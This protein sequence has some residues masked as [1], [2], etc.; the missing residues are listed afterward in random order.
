MG[1]RPFKNKE[2]TKLLAMNLGELTSQVKEK[3]NNLLN[4]GYYM[5]PEIYSNTTIYQ[6]C[7]D[8]PIEGIELAH[9]T[10]W[11]TFN[12]RTGNKIAEIFGFIIKGETEY[13]GTGPIIPDGMKV[14]NS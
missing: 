5:R 12:K 3:Y 4:K 6:L 2:P 11:A 14:Q 8:L 7:K 13:F 1:R 10:I 9:R